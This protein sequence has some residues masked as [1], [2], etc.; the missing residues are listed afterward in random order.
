MKNEVIKN[1]IKNA[2]YVVFTQLISLL[3]G[4]TRTLI[5]PLLLGVVDFGYWQVYML[6]LSYVG[7]FAL[8]FND[9]IY[10]KYGK[11]NYDELPKETFRSSIRIFIFIQMLI[12]LL[13]MFIVTFEPDNAKQ[14]SFYWA[15]LN[16]PIAGLTGILIHVFQI[17]N[18]LKKYSFYIVVDRLFTLLVILGIFLLR[19]DDFLI[20]IISDTIS[21][22]LILVLML[23]SCRDI[24]FGKGIKYHLAFAEMI[25]NVKIG[26]NLMLANF[27]GMLV[28]GFGKFLVERLANIQSFSVYSFAISTMNLVLIMISATGLVVYPTLNR[29]S[30]EKYPYYFKKLNNIL[31]I[32]V[33][34]L[35]GVIFP[36]KLFVSNYMLNFTEMVSYLSI[37]FAIIY[38][39]SKMQILIIPYYNLLRIET[40]LLRVNVIGIV[41]AVVTV[42][43]LYLL[44]KSVTMAAIGTLIAMLVR[45]Y[46]SELYLKNKLGISDN[47]NILRELCFLFL[48]V[49]LGL[50]SNIYLGIIGFLL[51]Y[52]LIVLTQKDGYR[53][54]YKYIIGR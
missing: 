10:L 47:G 43:P 48:F 27:I 26:V 37:L 25:D 31:T 51:L 53:D 19:L 32:I 38:A 9:G 41:V 46:V 21:R 33:F 28:I 17:T 18:Q 1:G 42:A 34:G 12:M 8:G 35:L 2:I 45:L 20:I 36:I 14:L 44:T 15:T 50:M 23:I 16:I 22:L 49:V 24:I 3:L 40:I 30:G 29:L 6:Y 4:I 5:L 7:I 11:Y 54:L 13:V 52:L 39:Q